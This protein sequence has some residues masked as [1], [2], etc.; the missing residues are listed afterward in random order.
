VTDVIFSYSRT[1]IAADTDW[2][3]VTGYAPIGRGQ[4]PRI[5]TAALA[6]QMPLL[7]APTEQDGADPTGPRQAQSVADPSGL[8]APA[9]SNG[10]E[11][12]GGHVAWRRDGR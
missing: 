2:R 7:V 1:P 12:R 3:V 9:V 5:P 6:G 10:R 11:G 8:S 4:P